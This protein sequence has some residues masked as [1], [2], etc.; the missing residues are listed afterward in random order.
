MLSDE[1]LLALWRG[2]TTA[3]VGSSILHQIKTRTA[4]AVV[5]W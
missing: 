4:D 2:S 5:E 3:I 1:E